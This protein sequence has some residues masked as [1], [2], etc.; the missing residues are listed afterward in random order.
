MCNIRRLRRHATCTLTHSCLSG[1][2]MLRRGGWP[3]DNT[4][5]N[6][7]MRNQTLSGSQALLHPNTIIFVNAHFENTTKTLLELVT[8]FGSRSLIL[9]TSRRSKCLPFF[10]GTKIIPRRHA[11]TK[12]LWDSYQT[13]KIFTACHFEHPQF[14]SKSHP[15]TRYHC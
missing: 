12:H 4:N 15:E 3:L 14:Q 13:N 7:C 8:T 9:E 5:G 1:L 2:N 10:R 6:S 11:R